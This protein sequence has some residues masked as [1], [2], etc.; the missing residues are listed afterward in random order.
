MDAP[1]VIS[2]GSAQLTGDVLGTGGATVVNSL[3][4]VT[5]GPAVYPA[6]S[7]AQ[8]TNI[9]Q[10][11]GLSTGTGTLDNFGQFT[12]NGPAGA[13]GCVVSW[14]NGAGGSGQ[15]S[16]TADGSGVFTIASTAFGTDSGHGIIW[17]TV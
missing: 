9:P 12:V 10:P 2:I 11:P 13:F 16:V 8:L 6:G 1:V 14:Y 17:I 7:A 5:Q 4:H 15:L 3:A